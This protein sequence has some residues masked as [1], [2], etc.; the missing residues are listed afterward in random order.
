MKILIKTF[1]T[2]KLLFIVYGF[3]CADRS[4]RSIDDN[5]NKKESYLMDLNGDL[6]YEVFGTRN[7]AN[8][9]ALMSRISNN[10]KPIH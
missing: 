7:I 8:E 3:I 5:F 6:K 2:I 4:F 10:E 9:A 1:K